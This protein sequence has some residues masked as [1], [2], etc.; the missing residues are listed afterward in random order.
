[1]FFSLYTLVDVLIIESVINI[2]HYQLLFL[3]VI[4]ES[5]SI[6]SFL[7]I[8]ASLIA[9]MI[10]I[11]IEKMLIFIERIRNQK[12]DMISDRCQLSVHKYQNI[13]KISYIS[14]H[15]ITIYNPKR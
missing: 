13:G 8:I 7:V 1:M 2:T 3:P 4:S 15:Y 12:I 10:L 11:I 5:V 14:Y 6:M 9:F